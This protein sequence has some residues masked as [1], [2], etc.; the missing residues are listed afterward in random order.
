M[1]YAENLHGK[2]LILHTGMEELKKKVEYFMQI[3]KEK[4]EKRKKAR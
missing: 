3:N 1:N 2:P 4:K